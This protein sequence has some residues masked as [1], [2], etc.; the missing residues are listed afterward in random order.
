MRDEEMIS[1]VPRFL[2]WIRQEKLTVAN[3]PT[4]Y[5]HEITA[6]IQ[7]TTLPESLRLV[8]IGGEA[9]SAEAWRRWKENVGP[10]ITLI[11]AYGPTEATVTATLHIAQTSDETLPIGRPIANAQM[12]LLDEDL[13]PVPVGQE[14]ELYLGGAGLSRGYLNR[15]ELTARRF[16]AN[17]FP[18]I[19]STRL[20]KTGDRARYRADGA[21]ELRCRFDARRR[22]RAETDRCLRCASRIRFQHQRTPGIHE[23]QVARPHDS[24]SVHAARCLSSDSFRQ[25]RSA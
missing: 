18:E 14:G 16:I 15:P 11:N 5:W 12:L 6:H 23:G 21:I 13:K 19:P 9:A 25:G 2:D 3:I 22:S 8:I 1:S 7:G 4:A 10:K 24:R 17:P 20:Y